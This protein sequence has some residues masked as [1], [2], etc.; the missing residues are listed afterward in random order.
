M[1]QSYN[2]GAINNGLQEAG[3]AVYGAASAME[4]GMAQA[5]QRGLINARTRETEED[6][7]RKA[8][9]RQ[10]L[11][12]SH[13]ATDGLV[14]SFANFFNGLIPQRATEVAPVPMP[15]ARPSAETMAAPLEIPEQMLGPDGDSWAPGQNPTPLLPTVRL[16]PALSQQDVYNTIN[17][18]V[19]MGAV[20]GDPKNMQGAIFETIAGMLSPVATEEQAFR[21]AMMNGK[22]TPQNN[23]YTLQGA[24][25][26]S[27][28][29][30][31]QAVEKKNIEADA[32]NYAADQ[33]L[34][35]ARYG[36]DRRYD[37]TVYGAD[38]RYEG[39]VYGADR[40]F[41][42]AVY[43]ADK[44]AETSRINAER[45][46]QGVTP[47]SGVT[48][49]PL[50]IPQTMDEQAKWNYTFD[51]VIADFTG[52][53]GSIDPALRRE[54]R[55]EYDALKILPENRN[56]SPESVMDDVVGNYDFVVKGGGFFK[57]GTVSGV[58]K[59]NAPTVPNVPQQGA[60][61][62]PAPAAKPNGPAPAAGAKPATTQP[63]TPNM[64][65]EQAQQS[66]AAARDRINRSTKMTPEQK[67]EELAKVDALLAQYGQK[68]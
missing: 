36:A 19:R 6:I 44:A 62:A 26:L 51:N 8:I 3:R 66:A 21:L 29:N 22:S 46:G 68:K 52:S 49:K 59:P 23:S 25:D 5:G 65:L 54:M 15:V 35:G 13:A 2:V 12:A 11:E 39:V 9:E 64:T 60:A 43:R 10:Q 67:A 61:T 20:K 28:R 18:L 34:A 32:K 45:K 1:G 40:R 17:G 58:R 31:A 7:R 33:R 41:D 57:N 14:N 53:E 63:A 48:T 55:R 27:A 4:Q 38:K 30:H 16:D 50:G 37:G 24:N 56:R 42:G 47:G